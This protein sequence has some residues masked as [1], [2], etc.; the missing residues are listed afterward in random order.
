M[1]GLE[2][3]LRP[4][5]GM[6]N[7]QIRAK[8]PARELCRELDG[9]VV[10]VRVRD[11]AMAMYFQI[12]PD[13]LELLRHPVDPDVTITGSLFTLAALAGQPGEAALRDGSIDLTGDPETAQA[14]QQLMTYGRPDLEEELSGLVGD[15]A[16]HGLGDLARRIGRWGTGARATMEQNITEYLQEESRALPSRYEVDRFRESVNTLR[17]DVDRLAAKIQR[18]EGGSEN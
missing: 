18:L 7:R 9:Q 16:A 2:R 14:F 6:V 12:G 10:A 3:L 1:N 15:V 17:D 13:E 11:T 8:T 4:V 5:V